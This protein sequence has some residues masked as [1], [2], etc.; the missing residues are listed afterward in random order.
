MTINNYHVPAP[1]YPVQ[2]Q[3]LHRCINHYILIQA[4]LKMVQRGNWEQ[5][6]F[7][8]FANGGE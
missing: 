2:D 3:L 8:K 4:A 1:R 7:F 5:K 6:D